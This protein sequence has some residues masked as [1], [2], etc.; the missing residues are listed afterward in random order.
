MNEVVTETPGPRFI[1]TF[2]SLEAAVGAISTLLYEYPGGFF[3]LKDQ[4]S[5][6]RIFV[7][8][9]WPEVGS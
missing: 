1:G 2:D 4:G 7:F 6:P 3:S 5:N 9:F 8:T